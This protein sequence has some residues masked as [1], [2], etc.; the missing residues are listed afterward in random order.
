MT[1]PPTPSDWQRRIEGD[2]HGT[3]AVFDAEAITPEV[4]KERRA[5]ASSGLASCVLFVGPRGEP[6]AAPRVSFTGVV[7]AAGEAQIARDAR[8]E[9]TRAVEALGPP[10][11][12]E[13]LSECASMA[14]R[15]VAGKALGKRPLTAVHVVRTP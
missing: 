10:L 11:T 14:V 9:I 8:E 13:R 3:P 6:S 7:E 4:L 1:T 12:D 5:L 2:W 15:R